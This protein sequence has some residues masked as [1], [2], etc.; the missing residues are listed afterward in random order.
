ML[1]R[2]TR[3]WQWILSLLEAFHTLKFLHWENLVGLNIIC[4]TYVLLRTRKNF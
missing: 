2:F 4:R 3:L 1:V